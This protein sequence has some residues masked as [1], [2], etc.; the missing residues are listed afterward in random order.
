MHSSIERIQWLDSLRGIAAL[1]VAVDHLF[2]GC[3]EAPFRSYWAEPVADNRH[4]YQ[5]PPISI[6][7]AAKSMV[8]LFMVLSGY[9]IS[10]SLVQTR[11]EATISRFYQKLA[12]AAFR[13]VFRLYI[14]VFIMATVAQIA[15]YLGLYHW[16]WPQLD[17]IGVVPWGSPVLHFRYYL[18]YLVDSLNI[19]D[20]SPNPGLN[21]QLWT[22]PR[23]LRGSFC[24][25][26]TILALSGINHNKRI[27]IVLL[28]LLHTLWHGNW[29]I[30]GFYS[31]LLIA[32]ATNHPGNHQIPLHSA[33][34]IPAPIIER[35]LSNRKSDG[36]LYAWSSRSHSRVF[37]KLFLSVLSFWLLCQP[38]EESWP[39]GYQFLQNL[40]P[41]PWRG[42]HWEYTK[43][44]ISTI[45]SV[46]LVILINDTPVLQRLLSARPLEFLGEAS[47]SLYLVHVIYYRCFRNPV[48]NFTYALFTGNRFWVDGI[49]PE[50]LPEYITWWVCGL[51]MIPSSLLMATYVAR[52]VDKRSAWWA[53][54]ILK[55]MS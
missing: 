9:S 27:C 18:A 53:H 39:P 52:H 55:W 10:V 30:F 1:I 48:M 41:P 54:A 49:A 22:I 47:F 51:V 33:K 8:A 15:L 21:D 16:W 2:M 26:L 43:F 29:D 45:G 40:V 31:G 37:K 3:I 46:G 5:L 32:E 42:R 19:L 35:K 7:F 50:P 14:P 12:S 20:I 28:I 23:E 34:D 6:I 25:Y 44:S 38:F 36:S 11:N 4:F 17:K 24:V 13:R